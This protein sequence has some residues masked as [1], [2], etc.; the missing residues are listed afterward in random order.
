MA[1][2]LASRFKSNLVL[3]F[4]QLNE[5]LSIFK[6]QIPDVLAGKTV[7]EASL[8][9]SFDL[10]I[11][12]SSSERK[13]HRT[14]PPGYDVST[15]GC[16]VSIGKERRLQP[17]Y[18]LGRQSEKITG[19]QKLTGEFM[20]NKLKVII[21]G[22]S[23]LYRAFYALPPLSKNGV[24]TNA[25]FGFLRMFLSIY[26]TLIRN[27]W[28]YLL[29]RAGKRSAQRCTVGIRLRE[30]RHLTNWYLSLR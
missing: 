20:E 4:V 9:R 10:N 7:L 17:L 1:V 25:V 11:I 21:D 18:S 24:Y 8:R 13:T 29:I 30:S 26:R 5:V 28:L 14:N 27:T 2:R 19:E 15:G 3:D 16:T 22:S 23:L 12:T 6:A